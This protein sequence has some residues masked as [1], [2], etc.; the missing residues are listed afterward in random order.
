MP[1]RGSGRQYSEDEIA[2]IE[3]RIRG[4]EHRPDIA[5]SLGIGRTTLARVLKRYGIEVYT[6]R[7][8]EID[9]RIDEAV[10][11]YMSNGRSYQRAA[12]AMRLDPS[13]LRK[14]LVRRG[15]D[16]RPN[17]ISSDIETAVMN[18]YLYSGLM[19]KD[20]VARN[21]VSEPTLRRLI[22]KHDLKRIVPAPRM[23][24]WENAGKRTPYQ[25]WVDKY[26]QEAADKRMSLARDRMSQ[27]SPRYGKPALQSIGAS[28]QGWYKG[29]YFRSLKELMFMMTELDKQGVQWVNGE[30][31]EYMIKYTHF[32]GR[33][34]TYRSDYVILSSRLMVEVK[35]KYLWETP[36]VKLKQEAAEIWCKEQGFTYML[37][38]PILDKTKML[39]AYRNG[40]IRWID[41][42]MVKFEKKHGRELWCCGS[43]DI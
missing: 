43:Y 14:A 36:L 7:A 17:W 8:K 1:P 30:Q 27:N 35:P 15:I 23:S 41:R 28:W 2:D 13:H 22:A 24:P 26:G 42:T 10:R 12:R 16:I 5:K 29:I 31:K 4:K 18:D 37:V 34:R 6:V 21:R 40:F 32:N 33:P 38:D 3:R 25:V 11:L 9:E 39:G 19:V 20:I